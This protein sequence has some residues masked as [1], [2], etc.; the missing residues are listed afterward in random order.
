MH[1]R[2]TPAVVP[3]LRSVMW[4]IPVFL[5]LIGFFHRAAPGVIA[6]DLMQAFD[7]TGATIG[8]A[9]ATYFYSLTG[10]FHA[11][12]IIALAD[13]PATAAAMGETNPTG[14]FRPELF[15][16]TLQMSA[17]LIRN[18]NRGTLMAEAEIV[19]R[20]RTTVPAEP[21]GR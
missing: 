18:T 16:L 8:L 13:E 20:G 1:A 19:H 10:P 14:E 5:F 6:R 11:G 15:P 7:A 21:P 2:V 12:A 17:N 9:A 4:A 3:S